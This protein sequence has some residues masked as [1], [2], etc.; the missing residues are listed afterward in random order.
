MCC[1]RNFNLKFTSTQCNLTIRTVSP[2]FKTLGNYC[3]T[4]EFLK[5]I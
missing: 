5:K 1:D 2:V 3:T 4:V